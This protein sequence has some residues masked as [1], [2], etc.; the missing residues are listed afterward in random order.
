MH[1]NPW[2]AK[3]ARDLLFNKMNCLR[4]LNGLGDLLLR[5]GLRHG[6]GQDAVLTLAEIWSFTTSSGST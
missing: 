3:Q 1:K 2:P 4:D 6:D 5:C